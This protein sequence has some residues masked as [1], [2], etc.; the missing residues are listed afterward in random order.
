M[1]IKFLVLVHTDVDTVVDYRNFYTA[2]DA[3]HWANEMCARGYYAVT[4][5]PSPEYV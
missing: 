3:A 5:R 4:T 2:E 1:T